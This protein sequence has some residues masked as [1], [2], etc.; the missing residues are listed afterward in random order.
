MSGTPPRRDERITND[1]YQT[2]RF[3]AYLESLG[4]PS[5]GDDSNDGTVIPVN[6]VTAVQHAVEPRYPLTSD[7][8]GFTV[9]SVSLTADMVEF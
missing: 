1:G 7:E 5:S 6:T 3:A 4:S 2:R 8:V 9:D